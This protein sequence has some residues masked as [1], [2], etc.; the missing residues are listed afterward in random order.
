MRESGK[1]PE[2]ETEPTKLDAGLATPD[3]EKVEQAEE[4]AMTALERAYAI[5]G[6]PGEDP[7]QDEDEAADQARQDEA[8]E[9]L[10]EQLRANLP[11]VETLAGQ[12]E[13]HVNRVMKKAEELLA[14]GEYFDAQ[15]LYRQATL[16]APDNPLAKVGLIHA[17]MGAGLIRS[18]SFNLKKLFEDHPELINVRYEQNIL[19]PK[20]RLQWLQ[21]ELQRMID[22]EQ[23][24]GEPG[25]MLAYLGHQTNSRQLVRYGLA[26]AEARAPRDPVLQVLRGVWLE[27]K[28]DAKPAAQAQD[29]PPAD[30][31]QGK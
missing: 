23:Y 6:R 30:P 24:A 15:D 7:K 22:S 26:V 2:K 14:E 16:S 4:K 27:T 8:I 31:A 12:T 18:A 28:S 11:R 29:P 17:Q 10:L 9:A 25:I 5:Y 21:G 20:E 3:K 1:E 13:H 19:P